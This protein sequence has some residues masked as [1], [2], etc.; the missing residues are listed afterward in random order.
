LNE[1]PGTDPN[2]PGDNDPG[3]PYGNTEVPKTGPI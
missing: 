2:A 1:R 3:L